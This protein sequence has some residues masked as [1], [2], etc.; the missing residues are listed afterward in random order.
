MFK[1]LLFGIGIFGVA[2][3]NAKSYH[4][5]L[6]EPYTVGTTHLKPGDYK[7][8]IDGSAAA[9]EDNHGNIEANGT[10]ENEERKF[11]NT[12]IVSNN[13]NG[14]SQIRVIELGGTRLQVDFK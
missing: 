11:D 1:K 12:S 9:L 5:T 13:A 14:A 4:V 7:L 10:L 6:S 8:V 2:F 3:A